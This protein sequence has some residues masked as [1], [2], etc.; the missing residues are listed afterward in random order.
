MEYIIGLDDCYQIPTSSCFLTS[1]IE[2]NR[3]TRGTPTQF[4]KHIFML[5]TAPK[6]KAQ[7]ND[8]GFEENNKYIGWGKNKSK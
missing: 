8:H 2:F 4:I 1:E 3:S 5:D 6:K 7:K